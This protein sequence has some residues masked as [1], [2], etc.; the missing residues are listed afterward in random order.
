MKRMICIVLSML[1][2][3]VTS[4]SS[5]YAGRHDDKK[6]SRTVVVN[7]NNHNKKKPKKTVVVNHKPNKKPKRNVV[8]NNNN[9]NHHNY[10]KKPKRTVIVNNNNYNH[11]P[12]R[13]VVNRRPK[14][15]YRNNMYVV[16]KPRV[17]TYRSIPRSSVR[18]YTTMGDYYSYNSKFYTYRGYDYV[19]VLPP[20]GMIIPNLYYGYESFRYGRE[21]YYN[22][23]GVL[24]QR[25]G[26]QFRV[27]EPIVGMVL[28]QMPD[29]GVSTIRINGR[30]YY[31][32]GGVI[33][34][35]AYING[36]T[37]YRVFGTL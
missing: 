11:K 18:I 13:V 4:V 19:R 15:V 9:Y 10:N 36:R 2:F 6:S 23:R 3:T 24:Y 37:R 14:P 27:V 12:N 7:H 34:D 33:Y 29:V 22:S 21:I 26:N 5:V 28:N 20:I 25:Y 1:I 32:C 8:V 31:E 35:R 30:H 16:N 17:R